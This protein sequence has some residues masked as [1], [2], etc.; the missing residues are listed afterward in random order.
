MDSE[1]NAEPESATTSAENGS[2]KKTAIPRAAK[3]LPTDRL[4]FDAQVEALKAFV[5]ES[6]NGQKAVTSAD[7]APHIGVVEATAS[8]NN[9]FFMDAGLISR[10]SKGRY[11]PKDAAIDF[12][13]SYGF[14]A[15]AAKAKLAEPLS[16]TW[17][18]AAV[19]DRVGIGN[20]DTDGVIRVLANRVV[21]CA[22][23]NRS[24]M[25]SW[26]GCSTRV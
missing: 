1:F 13:R 17:F 18:F 9:A 3:A 22:P 24:W 5:I 2:K 25:L 6:N 15:E 19:K 4:K 11:K 7:I 14:D 21:R 12:T 10:E 23:T 26:S 20:A 16:E 8:L